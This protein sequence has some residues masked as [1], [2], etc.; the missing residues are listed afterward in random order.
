MDMNKR[1]KKVRN[2]AGLN[3][4]KFAERIG[5]T[6]NFISLIETGMRIPSDRTIKDICREFN[7]NEIWLRTGEGGDENMFTQMSGE[8]RFSISLGKL[9][10]SQNQFVQNAI[11]ALA[12]S[13]PDTLKAIENLMRKCLGID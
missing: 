12:E 11:I 4:E 7:V 1:I 5:L 6:K 2:K 3:Q 13:D 9:A 10:V 8:D